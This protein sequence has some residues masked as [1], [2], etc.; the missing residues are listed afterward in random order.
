MSKEVT[1]LSRAETEPFNSGTS[2][3]SRYSSTISPP[4]TLSHLSFF[5]LNNFAGKACVS[6]TFSSFVNIYIAVRMYS[7][8]LG[9]MR[10]VGVY[11]PH[12][13]ERRDR[14]TVISKLLYDDYVNELFF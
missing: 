9:I 11:E 2:N 5:I 8:A 13:L 10:V 6:S 14:A 12:Y 3:S 4:P 1:T 7:Q